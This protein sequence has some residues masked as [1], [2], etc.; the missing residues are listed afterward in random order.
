MN[1]E[2]KPCLV[3]SVSHTLLQ[4]TFSSC[5]LFPVCCLPPQC[6]DSCQDAG[7]ITLWIRWKGVP[8]TAGSEAFCSLTPTSVK[9]V[10]CVSSSQ[11]ISS[12]ITITFPVALW[13]TWWKQKPQL[14]A[15]L[16]NTQLQCSCNSS[17]REG[18]IPFHTKQRID[19]RKFWAW[20]SAENNVKFL[21]AEFRSCV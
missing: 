6:L 5:Q 9:K 7:T 11:R 19:G 20:R 10:F 15:R 3:L 12:F 18:S 16:K 8:H 17:E 1:W 14:Q 13:V 21:L 4:Q 2:L